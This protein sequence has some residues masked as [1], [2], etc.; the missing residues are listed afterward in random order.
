M[1]SNQTSKKSYENSE[2]ELDQEP[3]LADFGRASDCLGIPVANLWIAYEA[4]REAARQSTSEQA[5]AL[6]GND[7][8]QR[9]HRTDKIKEG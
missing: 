3:T 9:N 7:S 5:T 2:N 4:A 1:K 6:R 8:R